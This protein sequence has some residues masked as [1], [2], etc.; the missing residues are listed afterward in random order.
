MWR[1]LRLKARLAD[2]SAR[3]LQFLIPGDLESP[4][5]GYGYDR[6]IIE[7]LGQLGWRVDV[8]ALDGSFPLP[9]AAALEQADAALSRVADGGLVMVDGLALGAM[10]EVVARHAGRVRLVALV[11]HPL[12]AETGLPAEIAA[13]LEQSERAAL[14]GARHVIV[15]SEATAA[16]LAPYDVER[17]RITVV[18]PGTDEVP[19]ARGGADGITR[20]LCVATVS[21]RKGHDLLVGALAALAPL[22][23]KLTCVGSLTMNADTVGALRAQIAWAGLGDRVALVGALTGEALEAAFQAADLFVLPTR[24][25]GYGMVVAE[26]L[27]RGLP[28]ISTR[29]GAIP[30][31]VGSE[32]GL[33]VPTDDGAALQDALARVLRAPALLASL[34]DGARKVRNQ[35]PRWP[36][37]CALMARVLQQVASA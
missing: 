16:A 18:V 19:L 12:A 25:E 27:A 32:A 17:S 6:R 36:D 3:S 33:I 37:S 10:P 5:G 30:D 11:H 9:G 23:W 2:V 15:T 7:G 13:R 20:L 14:R 31:L 35:L 1:G 34:R 26:A 24:H 21:P 29:T 28:V 8:V 22:P 4:T